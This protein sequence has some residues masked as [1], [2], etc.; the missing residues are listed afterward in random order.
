M[1]TSAPGALVKK[2]NK[3]RKSWNLYTLL[4]KSIKNATYN[5]KVA[6][7]NILN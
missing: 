4:F 2:P 6:L 3:V 7:F 1:L 5:A